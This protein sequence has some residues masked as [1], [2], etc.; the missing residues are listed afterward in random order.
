[1]DC[2]T[3]ANMADQDRQLITLAPATALQSPQALQAAVGSPIGVV[4]AVTARKPRKKVEDTTRR[5]SQSRTYKPTGRPRGRPPKAQQKRAGFFRSAISRVRARLGER[6]FFNGRNSSAE[7]GTRV[8]RTPNT[9]GQLTIGRSLI[10]VFVGAA[11]A[12]A[13][14]SLLQRFVTKNKGIRLAVTAG[15]AIMFWW[16]GGTVASAA[17]G[18]MIKLGGAMTALS[19]AIIVGVDYINEMGAATPPAAPAAAK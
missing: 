12:I 6:R 2:G 18:Q 8:K 19:G 15:I 13:A 9:P 10:A 11:V 16:I 1:M 7:V 4:Q 14:D 3:L 5:P 17:L